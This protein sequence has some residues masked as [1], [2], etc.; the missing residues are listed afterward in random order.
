MK[1]ESFVPRI[2]AYCGNFNSPACLDS[3]IIQ[4]AF[5]ERIEPLEIKV[6]HEYPE[7]GDVGKIIT[8]ISKAYCQSCSDF[9]TKSCCQTAR[10]ENA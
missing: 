4:M 8:E 1:K 6:G 3:D 2:F 7:A 5:Y 10:K 9:S